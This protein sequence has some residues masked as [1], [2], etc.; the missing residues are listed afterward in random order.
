MHTGIDISRKWHDK[1]RSVENGKVID[2]GANSG[3]GNYILIKHNSR[4][5]TFYAHLSKIYIKKGDKVYK[6]EVIGLEG[7]DP[8]KDKNHGISTGHHLHFE[9]RKTKNVESAVNPLKYI[10]AKDIENK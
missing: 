10:N 6:G 5:Y 3:Y 1:V 9:V 4:L 2:K 7:G 8:K